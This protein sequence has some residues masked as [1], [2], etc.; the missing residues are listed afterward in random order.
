MSFESSLQEIGT[1]LISARASERKKNAESLKSFLTGN[2]APSLLSAN[3]LKKRGYNW[4]NLFDD[5]HEYVLKVNKI[6][7]TLFTSS[8]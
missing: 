1:G 6:C 7:T 2:A 3:T 4:N 5:I 8:D